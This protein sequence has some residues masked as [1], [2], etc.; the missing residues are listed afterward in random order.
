V[1]NA[2]Y[3]QSEQRD[4]ST[5]Y[6]NASLTAADTLLLNVKNDASLIGAT[7]HADKGL[8]ANIGGNLT[9]ESLQNLAYGSNKGFGV[10]GGMGYEGVAG[11]TANTTAPGQTGDAATAN[12][13][14]SLSNGSYYTK[15]TVLSSITSGGPLNIDVA[16]H[17]DIT[18]ALIASI[19][20]SGKDT[21]QL[22]LNT[23][24]L[25]FTDLR[26]THQSSD[27][28][29]S[30]NTNVLLNEDKAPEK[31]TT[32]APQDSKGEDQPSGTTNLGIHQNSSQSAGKTL[33]TIGNGSITVGGEATEPEGLNRDVE[34]IDKE[35]YAIDRV[36][37]DLD[38]TVENKTLEEVADKVSEGAEA[39]TDALGL[40]GMSEEERLALADLIT[41]ALPT[42]LESIRVKN[43]AVEEK[44][45]Q[46]EREQLAK[47]LFGEDVDLNAKIPLK[48]ENGDIIY[49]SYAAV[50]EDFIQR[51]PDAYQHFSDILNSPD[52]ENVLNKDKLDFAK[53]QASE[54][55]NNYKKHQELFDALDNFVSPGLIFKMVAEGVTDVAQATGLL[56]ATAEKA[57][58]LQ[59][60]AITALQKLKD[61]FPGKGASSGSIGKNAD[62]ASGE[63]DFYHKV[64]SAGFDVNVNVNGQPLQI[65]FSD[66]MKIAA[67]PEKTT[68]VLGKYSYDGEDIKT[69]LGQTKD[70]KSYDFGD[71]KGGFNI[72]NIP[73]NVAKNFEGSFWDSCNSRA[74]S[75]T[76]SEQLA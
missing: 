67:N 71:K 5:S 48:D 65:V 7:I 25:S 54:W 27:S 40:T 37:G 38:L 6:T 35:L 33:A 42:D 24:S 10:S 36:K 59:G 2:S 70:P 17:T 61:V 32:K 23:G 21:G 52:L 18:G 64:D 69:A 39:M 76:F 51:G 13:G 62:S 41:N 74:R 26:N 66:G 44:L 8:T 55:I 14:V 58:E 72:L 45:K 73:D 28:T 75:R 68:T 50:I 22:T 15:E 46:Q 43:E 11:N 16:G 31:G 3:N 53:E 30:L 29:V 49:I 60:A 12:A 56:K 47:T 1:V 4:H 20:E 63:L 19:D 9:L 57:G 34:E